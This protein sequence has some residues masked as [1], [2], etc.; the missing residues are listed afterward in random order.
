MLFQGYVC[1]GRQTSWP[2][3][4]EKTRLSIRD[5]SRTQIVRTD[6][7]G[8][9]FC[10][11]TALTILSFRHFQL[12]RVFVGGTSRPNPDRR[13]FVG[14]TVGT[15]QCRRDRSK[16]AKP[17]WTS[18]RE[19]Y[20]RSMVHALYGKKKVVLAVNKRKGEGKREHMAQPTQSARISFGT[21]L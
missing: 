10:F 16:L 3:T 7:L 17:W 20:K 11:M 15:Y 1:A 8:A 9:P 2:S 4:R 13:R 14:I 21:V 19:V 12:G 5:D 6:L 18:P